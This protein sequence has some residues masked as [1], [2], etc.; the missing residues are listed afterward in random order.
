MRLSVMVFGLVCVCALVIGVAAPLPQDDEDVRGA[1]LTSRPKEKV[2]G[3]SNTTAKPS[4]RTPPKSGGGTN[5]GKKPPDKTPINPNPGT[6]P[7]PV[8]PVTPVNARRIGLGVTLF[9]RDSN[10]LAVRVDPDHVFRK[11][12]RVRI[13]LETNSDGYLY[14]FNTTDDGPATLIY[15]DVDLDDAGNYLQAHVPFEIPASSSPEERLRWFAFDEVA[16]TEHIFFVFTREP[17]GGV[18][19]EDDLIAFCREAKERCPIKPSTEIWTAVQKEMQEP[20]KTDKSQQY[21]RAQTAGE[22]EATA[23]GFGLA[24]D[25]PQPSLVMMAS[26]ARSKLVATLDLI[27]K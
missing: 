13:L 17:L 7:Q 9:M 3:G 27:H 21:G 8:D 16:G 4:R 22:T 20:L 2:S 12:D 10:G 26:S 11:G 18:P 24:K 1:F 23:R 25:D 5:P 19:I 6:K 14:I 15:P